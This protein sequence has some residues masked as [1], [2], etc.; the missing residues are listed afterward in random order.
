MSKTEKYARLL[1]AIG[2]TVPFDGVTLNKLYPEVF[3]GP[4]RD[5]AGVEYVHVFAV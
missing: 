5:V 4:S 1:E 3:I 2:Y